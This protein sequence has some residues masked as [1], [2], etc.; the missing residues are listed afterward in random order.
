MNRSDTVSSM[1]STVSYGL[2]LAGFWTA[3]VIAS[4]FWNIFQVKNET[5][6]AACIQ[7]RSAFRKDIIYRR[8]NSMLGG[9]YVTVTEKTPPNPYLT[10]VP[11]RD[12]QTPSGKR[13]TL[14][15]PAYM[16]RLAFELGQ[17]EQGVLSHIT[18]LK[19]IRP[20]NAP[21]TW[22][23]KALRAFDL[24]KN[25]IHSVETINGQNYLRLMRP[26]ITERSCLQCHAQQ[27]YKENDIRGGI[28]VAI[29]MQPL[30]SIQHATII[31]LAFINALF[32]LLGIGGITFGTIRQIKNN[33]KRRQDEEALQQLNN[34]LD[35]RVQ[36]R[37]Q[38]LKNEVVAHKRTEQT[39]RK[40]EAELLAIYNHSPLIM[41][42]VDD[43]RRVL[44]ANRL[45]LESTGRQHNEIEGLHVGEALKCIHAFDDPDG[46]GF[47]VECEK[48]IVRNTVL[49]SIKT[50]IGQHNVEAPVQLD[51]GDGVIDL[52]FLVST[53][54]LHVAGTKR[55]LVCLEDISAS[56][57]AEEALK[58]SEERFRSIIENT[59]AGYFFINS[60]GCF[61]QVN[62]AWLRMH[63]YETADE[64]IGQHY[65]LTQVDADLSSAH[66]KVEHLLDGNEIIAGEFSRRC[67]DGTIGYHTFSA[68]SVQKKGLTIGIEGFLIDITAHKMM[69][70]ELRQ[71][72]KMESIG[73]MAGGIAHDFNNLLYMIIGN[74]ELSLEDIPDWN[75][76]HANLEEIKS[77]SLRAAGIVK[78]LLNFSR[79]TDV[80]MKPIGAIT[81]IKEA[82]KF[83]RS[84]IPATIKINKSLPDTDVII[85]ADPVQIDQ[86][87]INICTNASQSMEETGGNLTINVENV[88]LDSEA[89]GRYPDLS[90]GNYL[91]IAISDTGSGIDPENI[92]RIFDPYFTTKEFGKGS[93]M[94]L[95]VVHG[96]VKN[97]GGAITVDSEPGKGATFTILLPVVD[98]KPEIED[99]ITD[100]VHIGS[101]TILFVDDEESIANM[102]GKML[103][104]LGYQVE[105][106]TNP[107]TALELFKSKPD[108][109]DLVIT[110]M[111]M[112]QMTG[113]TL[114]EKLKNVRSDIP[115]IICTGH[116]SLIDE[117]KAKGLGIDAYVMKPIVKSDIARAI[118]KV[119]DNN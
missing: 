14:M 88:D 112:P 94:G 58:E 64:I 19:P 20:E 10:N 18:S 6:E 68:R 50:G 118:R 70:K 11:E 106:E 39:L 2:I 115:V 67:K 56:K 114:S 63:K 83:L 40:S 96:I 99:E 93:G 54:P 91:I 3:L 34:E 105:T 9:V 41:L 77:A 13:L 29:P 119:L 44:K 69:E 66:E 8:W 52:F 7:A 73:T 31:R 49:D 111:T 42:I 92:D 72:H 76:V 12:I 100:E 59:D 71:A 62:L 25:E 104:R 61:Q 110:D 26:L 90:A 48:C 51:L 53:S 36:K 27:G 57:R 22:E 28:S 55:T 1:T 95:T 38:N 60:K 97:H 47:G 24:G 45:A 102:S 37:T 80:E 30:L 85:L 89:A 74:T 98:E 21:D 78:Q 117:E 35:A 32:W 86:T 33:S 5:V 103:K 107:A 87:L 17:K 108:Q 4:L 84:M 116:S 23:E 15:N 81:V 43:D 65:S 16:T 46:C 109:F 79:K 101:E 82:L 75:P 113:V